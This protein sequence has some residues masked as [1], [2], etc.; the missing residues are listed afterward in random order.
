MRFPI[1]LATFAA[2]LAAAHVATAE[3]PAVLPPQAAV[4]IAPAPSAAGQGAIVDVTRTPAPAKGTAAVV[5]PAATSAPATSAPATSAPA[6]S[7]P[8]AAKRAGKPPSPKAAELPSG[9]TW[10][11]VRKGQ[12]LG[13]IA[14]RHHVTIDA[15]CNANELT[16]RD[17]L[18]PGM[19][20]II[21]SRSDVDGALARASH[22]KKADLAKPEL[23]KAGPVPLDARK[24]RAVAQKVASWQPYVARPKKTGIVTIKSQKGE[25]HGRLVARSGKLAPK[26][27]RE[28]ERVL[29]AEEDATI[30][31]DLL[32]LLA[33]VSD[34]FGGLPLNVVSGYR[35]AGTAEHSRH[36]L[37]KALDFTVEGVPLEALRDYCKSHDGVGV[38]YYPNSGFIHLDVRERWTYWVDESGR[39]EPPRYVETT[40]KPTESAAGPEVRVR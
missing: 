6:K 9:M 38:G 4:V 37:G 14:K 2:V 23:A 7:R 17:K 29:Y 21:P 27:R 24:S 3:E 36:K 26:A 11:S 18:Q 30:D 15:L 28:A 33:R 34:T 35:T 13:S 40:V 16:R 39:G 1:V 5:K 22:G 19:K 8:A 25:F 12:R 32:K 10:H 31:A 20:L